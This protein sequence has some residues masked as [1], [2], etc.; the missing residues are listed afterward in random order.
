[1]QSGEC[2]YTVFHPGTGISRSHRFNNRLRGVSRMAS[3]EIILE[4]YEGPS[5]SEERKRELAE[6]RNILPKREVWIADTSPHQ[7]VSPSRSCAATSISCPKAVRLKS[8]APAAE[9]SP[10]QATGNALRGHFLPAGAGSAQHGWT[11]G[12]VCAGR[13]AGRGRTVLQRPAS[14]PD[15]ASSTT[16]HSS[17]STSKKPAPLRKTSG[18]GLLWV[19]LLPSETASK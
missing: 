8:P 15:T 6:R 14:A 17:G 5:L 4:R 19:M 12:T 2:R 16:R 1:M 7:A 9:A 13:S 3:L 10:T 18:S 11:V